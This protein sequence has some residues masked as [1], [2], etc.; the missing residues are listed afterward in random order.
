VQSNGNAHAE[1]TQR[2]RNRAHLVRLPTTAYPSHVCRRGRSPR[3]GNGYQ[4]GHRAIQHYRPTTTKA[5]RCA[6]TPLKRWRRRLDRAQPQRRAVV[7]R[8]CNQSAEEWCDKAEKKDG[9]GWLRW[10]KRV[11]APN[12]CLVSHEDFADL[13]SYGSESNV[14]KGAPWRMK[15][16]QR[17]SS[18]RTSFW[19]PFRLTGLPAGSFLRAAWQPKRRPAA[20]LWRSGTATAY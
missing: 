6:A 3:R 19:P 2:V 14:T 5:S 11:L 16:A 9:F 15:R 8:T 20:N 12:G 1:E 7:P 18:G 17:S 10:W 13:R 4:E